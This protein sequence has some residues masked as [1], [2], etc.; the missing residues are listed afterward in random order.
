MYISQD[1]IIFFIFI[2]NSDIQKDNNA[3]FV[4]YRNLATTAIRL[5]S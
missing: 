3:A 5:G 4:F 2:K 1:K